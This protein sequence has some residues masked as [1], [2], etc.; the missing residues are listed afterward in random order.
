MDLYL[1]PFFLLYQTGKAVRYSRIS[2]RDLD[3]NQAKIKGGISTLLRV[4][5]QVFHRPIID[6]KG[7]RVLRIPTADYISCLLDTVIG[8]TLVKRISHDLMPLGEDLL[9]SMWQETASILAINVPRGTSYLDKLFLLHASSM[10][11][12]LF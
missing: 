11:N 12:A 7:I 9:A 2:W 5:R 10:K 6:M 1:N 4:M 8:R 3:G